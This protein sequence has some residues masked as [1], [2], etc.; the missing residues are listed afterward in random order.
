MK[1]YKLKKWEF[2]LPAKWWEWLYD[3]TSFWRVFNSRN[4]Y[5]MT[6]RKNKR[7]YLTVHLRD[8][9]TSRNKVVSTHRIIAETF[10]E[11]PL[12][13]YTVDHIDGNKLNN[14]SNNLQWMSIWD[15]VR[16]ASLQWLLKWRKTWNLKWEEH[17]CAKL[18][19]NIVEDIRN[20]Y[21]NWVK[22]KDIWKIYWLP[23]TYIWSIVHN[24]VWV[25]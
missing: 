13:L 16:K 24:R 15:N 20:R 21:N 2:S 17:W 6:Q 22:Q 7:W 1:K 18:N 4:W 9:K 12:N 5:E 19:W 8:T 3:V 25:I 11:N 14:N 23:N 10:I